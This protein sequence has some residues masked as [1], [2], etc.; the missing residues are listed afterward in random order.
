M[1]DFEIDRNHRLFGLPWY[2]IYQRRSQVDRP[3]VRTK[4]SLDL[5]A[6]ETHKHT[7]TKK[8]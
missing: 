8:L 6:L 3:R 2:S 7:D 5:L 1:I 4:L